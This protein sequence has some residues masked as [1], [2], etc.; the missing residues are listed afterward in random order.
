MHVLRN[1][2]DLSSFGWNT[3]Y[4]I[5]SAVLDCLQRGHPSAQ[6]RLTD[7]N[8]Q[9]I[10]LDEA[11]LS[12]PQLHTLDITVGCIF[13]C[14]FQY[15]A[16][17]CELPHLK[18]L[19][20]RGGNLK[21]LRIRFV[22][23]EHGSVA[24]RA[25]FQ[26]YGAADVGP[27][28][29]RFEETDKFPALEELVLQ[30]SENSRIEYDL[31]AKHCEDWK[32]FMNWSNMRTLDL[33]PKNCENLLRSLTGAVVTGLQTLRFKAFPDG[34]ILEAFF[35][36]VPKLAQLHMTSTDFPT[37]NAA[38]PKLEYFK[39]NRGKQVAVG[40]WTPDEIRLAAGGKYDRMNVTGSE[41]PGHGDYSHLPCG[42]G[43]NV[44]TEDRS[45]DFR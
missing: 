15:P 19:L 5:P 43:I 39:S 24:A 45:R 34:D 31:G 1:V 37:F 23:L 18:R 13:Y 32:R 27:L 42:T 11:L 10:P 26:G 20:I 25:R 8:R 7:H 17:I 29:F 33:G 2:K 40:K 38:I 22:R 35:R 12:S 16:G 28:N 3:G 41:R 4:Q 9:G 30:Q 6:L 44:L 14:K 36:C 21:I